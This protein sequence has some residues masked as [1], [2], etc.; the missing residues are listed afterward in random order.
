MG[1]FALEFVAAFA[2]GL[3]GWTLLEYIIHNVL[4]HWPKGKTLVS[5]EHI[6]HHKNILYFSPLPLKIRGAVP[7][8][9][10]AGVLFW[11]AFGL[12]C[13]LGGVAAL[14][15]GWTTYETLHKSIHVNGP[16]TRYGRWAAKNHLYHHFM[17]PNRNHGVTTPLWDMVFRTHDKIDVVQVREKD[18]NDIP[19]LNAAFANPEAAPAYLHDYALRT[20]RR[21]ESEAPPSID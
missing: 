13:A 15:L 8:L 2:A 5:A 16:R 7:V 12:P 9:G 3:A 21:G 19:W 4:G 6:K 18:L 17:R 10:G 14:S 11:L 20:S 1:A